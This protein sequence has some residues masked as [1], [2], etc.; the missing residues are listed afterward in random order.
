MFIDAL[1]ALISVINKLEIERL[2]VNNVCPV[3]LT[4]CANKKYK[5]FYKVQSFITAVLF[6]SSNS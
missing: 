4:C 3:N 5:E 2:V 1:A 6:Y